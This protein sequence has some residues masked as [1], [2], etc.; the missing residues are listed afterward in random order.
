M[1]EGRLELLMHMWVAHLNK[2]NDYWVYKKTCLSKKGK[3][4][5]QF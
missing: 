2:V 5:E 4:L 3:A 1:N